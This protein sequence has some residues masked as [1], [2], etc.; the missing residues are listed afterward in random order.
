L[1]RCNAFDDWS[2]K[3][4]KLKTEEPHMGMKEVYQEKIE[5]QLK[6]WSAKINEL[7]AKAD[8]ASA[9]AKSK[10]YQEIE[11]LKPKM[12]AAQKKLNDIKAAGAE[13]WENLKTASEKT[14]EELKSRWKIVKNKYL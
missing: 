6:E 14:M 3:K 8:Q 10:I 1:R 9:D 5:A 13:K 12:E 11:D 7:K 2:G 4:V